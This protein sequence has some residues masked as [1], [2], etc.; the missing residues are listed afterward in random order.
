M[1]RRE[2]VAGNGVTVGVNEFGHFFVRV[3]LFDEAVEKIL[4]DDQTSELF[5]HLELLKRDFYFEQGRR[6]EA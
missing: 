5:R 6:Y 3:Q 2:Y 1:T 4:G